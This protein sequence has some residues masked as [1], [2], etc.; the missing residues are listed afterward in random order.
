[1]RRSANRRTTSKPGKSALRVGDGDAKSLRGQKFGE[2]A[3]HFAATADNQRPLA[4]ALSLRRDAGL[5]LRR[6]RGLN[7]LPQQRFG[8]VGRDLQALG[9]RCGPAK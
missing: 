9:S 6:Q 5:F 4:A 7:E 3:A 8:Q 1:M 2:P